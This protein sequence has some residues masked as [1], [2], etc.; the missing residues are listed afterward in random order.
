MNSILVQRKG[1]IKELVISRENRGNSL[2]KSCVDQLLAEFEAARK[3]DE[4]K[5]IVVSGAGSRFFCTGHDLSDADPDRDVETGRESA[6][7]LAD[8][9]IAI[10]EAPQ[11]VIAR[12]NGIASG[13]GCQI[14]ASC[15]LAVAS[16]SARFATPGINI[17][18]WCWGPM[19][20]LS[21]CAAPKHSLNMLVRGQLMDAQ[22]AER[23]GLVNEV[24]SPEVLSERVEEIS[25]ELTEK[26]S[27][28]LSLGKRAFYRQIDMSMEQAFSYVG[29][30]AARNSQHEDAQEGI[31]A[32]LE[33]RKPRWTGRRSIY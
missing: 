26:S 33:K 18:F 10:R 7:H 31:K 16:S 14:V 13:G 2:T 28:T 11:I 12:V 5:V 32:F 3:A 9:T 6:G 25:L 30:L 29:E 4:L 20:V 1:A 23:I 21:R 15:D 8:L 24:V 17:G 19:V 22:Y 27:Y